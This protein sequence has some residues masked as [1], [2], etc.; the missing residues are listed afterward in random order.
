M[1]LHI[2]LTELHLEN[3]LVHFLNKKIK[4]YHTFLLPI[5]REILFPFYFPSSSIL[6]VLLFRIWSYHYSSYLCNNYI[7]VDI[8]CHLQDREKHLQRKHGCQDR[9]CSTA[10]ASKQ[11]STCVRA[12]GT[13]EKEVLMGPLLGT[14]TV[15][16]WDHSFLPI[17]PWKILNDCVGWKHACSRAQGVPPAKPWANHVPSWT[18]GPRHAVDYISGI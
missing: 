10:F 1:L 14:G 3:S 4:L 8:S 17:W 13:G 16:L 18:A 12:S 15:M 6:P 11:T 2:F 7:L 9:F 5:I